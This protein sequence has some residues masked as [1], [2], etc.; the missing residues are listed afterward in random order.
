MGKIGSAMILYAIIFL[1]I[2][3]LFSKSTGIKLKWSKIFLIALV[4]VSLNIV[5]NYSV[6]C[7]QLLFILLSYFYFS[8]RK[9]AEHIFYGLFSNV[10]VETLVRL[11]IFFFFPVLLGYKI[12]E[13]YHNSTLLI[14]SYLLVIPF[15]TFLSY[16]FSIDISLIRFINE[17]MIKKWVV[18]MN[19]IMISYFFSVHI[20]A[21]F[22]T[23]YHS[24][25]Y[26]FRPKLILAYLLILIFFI[27]RWDRFTK[28]QLEK[29]LL[30]A[31]KERTD[32]LEKY[33]HYIEQFYKDTRAIKHDSEN[34]MISLKDSVDSGD[35]KE[36]AR[37][38]QTV[39]KESA[40][41]IFNHDLGFCGLENIKESV[42]RSLLNS[43]LLE[44][45]SQGIDL[46][47]EVPET[48][49]EIN[50]KLLDLVV[51][52]SVL[53]DT[54][55]HTATGSIRPFISIA[56]FYQGNKQCFIIENSTKMKQVKMAKLFDQKVDNSHY[57]NQKSISR[58]TSILETYPN[59]NFS[60]R[61]N[62]YRLRQILEMW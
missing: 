45:Q 42:I 8:D 32:N 2:W 58:L 26:Q 54:A 9:F 10:L 31:Q 27:L 1:D 5:F 46:Y 11:V 14:L 25:Y 43:K 29:K 7:N 39:V 53:L 40:A 62:H 52:L 49:E 44:A 19:I 23:D 28:D 24:L 3:L 61:S 60:T 16:V 4:F 20:M 33:N 48:I 35:L 22:E 15:F 6:L 30:L 47:I 50:F 41:P 36:I 57:L 12:G 38:Y 59:T 55:I 21:Y 18:F 56:Y 13:I 37:V 34:I 51:V 17:D